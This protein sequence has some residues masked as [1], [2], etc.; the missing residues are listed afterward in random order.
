MLWC[1][2]KIVIVVSKLLST[3]GS[4]LG[5]NFENDVSTF[6]LAST[7]WIKPLGC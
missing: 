4:K 6:K 7:W 2:N 3:K 1:S 5:M